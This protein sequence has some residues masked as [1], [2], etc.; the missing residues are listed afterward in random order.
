MPNNNGDAAQEVQANLTTMM[1]TTMMG[2]YALQTALLGIRRFDGRNM[3]LKDFI[4]DIRNGSIYVPE[5][6]TGQYVKAIMGRLEGSARDSTYGRQFQ[7]LEELIKHLKNRFAPGKNYAYYSGKVNNLRMTQG[8]SVGDFYDKLN[9]LLSG[10]KNALTEEAT[11]GQ[12]VEDMVLPLTR[13]AID[14]FIRGLPVDIARQVDSTKP[15]NLEE[16]YAEA[17]RVESRMEARILPDTR[18]RYSRGIEP[19][20]ECTEYSSAHEKGPREFNKPRYGQNFGR[21]NFTYQPRPHYVGQMASWNGGWQPRQP[22][23]NYNYG[24]RPNFSNASSSYRNNGFG[25]NR[26]NPSYGR[27]EGYNNP[28]GYNARQTMGNFQQFNNR[29]SFDN[30]APRYNQ[31]SSERRYEDTHRGSWRQNNPVNT[32]NSQP[33]PSHLNSQAA[34]PGGAVASQTQSQNR[35]VQIQQNHN[36]VGNQNNQPILTLTN[37]I[38]EITDALCPVNQLQG[39][40]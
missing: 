11:Q 25:Q 13:S 10:A 17:I 39:G 8:D 32:T 22:Q 35:Q 28:Q 24:F 36:R 27:N 18:S 1:M 34:R 3:P 12:N 2:N 26:S 23:Q 7:N 20:W 4:Q 31:W 37:E 9:I 29:N 16:A 14:V 30:S 21:N 33:G 6:Q 15:K 38:T 5:D 19:R 40:Q